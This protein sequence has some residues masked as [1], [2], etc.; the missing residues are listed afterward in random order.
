VK[1][2]RPKNVSL[3]INHLVEELLRD[4]LIWRRPREELHLGEFVHAV[5][6]LGVDA[7]G[8]RFGAV[9]SGHGDVLLGE[10]AL[11]EGGVGVHTCEGD[12]GGPGEYEL[13]LASGV[14]GA[15][16]EGV[17]LCLAVG[18]ARLEA[19]GGG[20]VAVHEAGRADLAPAGAG[21]G[22]EGVADECLFELGGFV[23]EIVPPPAGGAAGRGEVEDLE[24][25]SDV[26]VGAPDAVGQ[27]GLGFGVVVDVAEHAWLRAVGRFVAGKVWERECESFHLRGE[28][29]LGLLDLGEGDLDDARFFEEL[30]SGRRVG[31]FGIGEA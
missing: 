8:A 6:P 16:C 23:E 24:L 12:L 31:V 7:A 20:D 17:D 27:R 29:R 1:P 5:E 14:L 28:A 21:R 3:E 19:A 11:L 30:L 2:Q 15:L 9:A 13:G 22:R 25:G 18:V 4:I 26:D 10:V